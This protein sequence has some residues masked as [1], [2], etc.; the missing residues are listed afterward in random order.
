MADNK[1]ASEVRW[2]LRRWVS[3]EAHK[4]TMRRAA[5]ELEKLQAEV[6][7]LRKENMQLRGE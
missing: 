7:S 4:E 2:C 3:Q 5:D 1:V 6:D